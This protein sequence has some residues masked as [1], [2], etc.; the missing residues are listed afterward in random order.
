MS[1]PKQW[2]IL[3]VEDEVDG[4]EVVAELLGY[5]SITSDAVGTAEEGLTRLTEQPYNGAVIDLALPGMDGWD[6]LR[7]IRSNPQ[8]AALP[9]VAITAY[10]TSVV[11]QQ[12]IEA[13]F[14]A[15]FPKPLD[16]STFVRELSRVIEKN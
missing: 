12:A 5:F 6:L 1:S 9:C 16:D 14:D 11:R 7:A 10:H 2:R 3:V 13:G 15:Y 8:T 4:Q